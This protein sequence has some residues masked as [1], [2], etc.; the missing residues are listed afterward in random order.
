MDVT[1]G[2]TRNGANVQLYSNND[3]V[4][5]RWRFVAA[6][7]MRERLNE[8][9]S[10]SR[11]VLADGTYTFASSAKRSMVL[12]VAA[13]SKNSGANVQLYSSNGTNAQRW[14]VS[15]DAKGYVTL[16]NV[17][18]GKVLD[19]AGGSTSN[20]TN[21]QQY[22]S[23]G[24]W[25]QKWIAVKNADGSITLRSAVTENRVT[26]VQAGLTSNGAN[27]WLYSSNGTNAQHWVPHK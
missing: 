26:D 15:H 18:S 5:Q 9:A 23:N 10:R 21:I 4:A 1:A 8:E 16:T 20:G 6:K 17:G 13:G 7:T 22:I 14:K 11:P 2:S 19:V 12:D 27:V 25:A 3:T 24:T